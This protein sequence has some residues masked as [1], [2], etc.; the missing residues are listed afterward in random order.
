MAEILGIVAAGAQFL[1]VA[2][3]LSV[4]LHWVCSEVRGAPARLRDLRTSLDQQIAL[5]QNI[6]KNESYGSATLAA[7][8][9][10][11]TPILY[12]YRDIMESLFRLLS[13]LLDQDDKGII[14][15]G[16]NSIF[17]LH[18]NN[19]ILLLCRR[20][21]EKRD[22]VLLWLGDANVTQTTES[23]R[24]SS[25][26]HA[27]S[28]EALKTSSEARSLTKGIV[29]QVGQIQPLVQDI[30]LRTTTIALEARAGII[31][32][33]KILDAIEQTNIEIRRLCDERRGQGLSGNQELLHHNRFLQ[34]TIRRT[35]IEYSQG[36]DSNSDPIP[37]TYYA[38]NQIHRSPNQKVIRNRERRNTC[39]CRSF[40]QSEQWEPLSILHFKRVFIRH[41]HQH[42]PR[43]Q[44]SG[45][46]LEIMMNIIPPSWL[47]R[48]TISLSMAVHNWRAG[49]GFKISPIVVGVQRT[50]SRDWSSS[51][52]AIED[53]RRRLG[54][55]FNN[56]PLYINDLISTLKD[57]FN[58]QQAS[59][60]DVDFKGVTLL[61]EILWLYI[62]HNSRGV[63]GSYSP[64]GHEYLA[65][66]RFMLDS[67]AN[68]NVE[69]TLA[70]TDWS[71]DRLILG[72]GTILDLFASELRLLSGCEI[73]S[74]IYDEL[75]TRGGQFSRPLQS[76]ARIH[77][78][79]RTGY[80]SYEV[81]ELHMFPEQL[82]LCDLG[83]LVPTILTQSE[84]DF[85]KV[86]G[87]YDVNHAS[88]VNGLTAAHF[89][90]YW[91]FALRALIAA[92]ADID[93]SD[94]HSR[95]PIHLAVDLH[96]PEAVEILIEADCALWS[97]K[98]LLSLHQSALITPIHDGIS[99]TVVGG[100]ID[101]LGRLFRLGAIMLSEES[102]LRQKINGSELDETLAPAII[103]ELTSSKVKIPTALY[104][105][106]VSIFNSADINGLIRIPTHVVDRFWDAGFRNVAGFD[107]HGFSP[108]LYSWLAAN[109]SM[110]LWLTDK[111][112]PIFS[113]HRDNQMCGLHLYA[114][115]LGF[116]GPSFNYDVNA[117]PSPS[118]E[119][120]CQLWESPHSVRDACSCLCSPQGC[121]PVSMLIKNRKRRPPLFSSDVDIEGDARLLEIFW[122][123]TDVPLHLRQEQA[124]DLLRLTIFD[125]LG[126]DHICCRL[127][128]YGYLD[129]RSHDPDD[130]LKKLDDT[131]RE[132]LKFHLKRMSLCKCQGA[133]KV[134]CALSSDESCRSVL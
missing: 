45:Q 47:L 27:T 50:V 33:E 35:A 131:F 37:A 24:I 53:T 128:R 55:N 66:V 84:R 44:N 101:R 78:G 77:G 68:P 110:A 90:V 83:P 25:Q 89:A 61:H 34:D 62:R 81:S 134:P 88:R 114:Y 129:V 108:M 70:D 2:V 105:D 123:K 122:E 79:Y 107:A 29:R 116:P 92:G 72:N 93:C 52:R 14:C 21:E 17:T 94:H 103:N 19:E 30:D 38:L 20:I 130:G 126:Y 4:K 48:Y 64:P 71:W 7:G 32:G 10:N 86:L 59:A 75:D 111:G 87:K 99:H 16:W 49:Q 127:D 106:G 65:L 119:L 82:D 36:L 39:Q 96:L 95:R 100:I 8:K 58:T 118:T 112:V 1:D 80:F 69:C 91:P 85:K 115:R 57:L 23:I 18:K 31:Q 74:L 67:G 109:F 42:C 11:V 104:S 60:L 22:L 63:M 15:K 51:F 120:G 133:D 56:S 28:Q 121:S 54:S 46:S 132:K 12:E 13:R 124:E 9:A 40:G 113:Q 97:S 125:L 102:P 98:S 6:V 117:I 3:R 26:S 76:I 73:G 43:S 5:V 41:H